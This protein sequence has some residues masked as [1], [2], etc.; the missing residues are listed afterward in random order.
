M[1][2]EYLES[3]YSSQ[4]W[5]TPYAIMNQQHER[6][7]PSCVFGE[8]Q[9]LPAHKHTP[10]VCV[11][12]RAGYA[13]HRRKNGLSFELWSNWCWWEV[14][15]LIEIHV[16]FFGIYSQQRICWV[17][18]SG[19]GDWRHENAARPE[20]LEQSENLAGTIR[21]WVAKLGHWG[22]HGDIA[23]NALMLSP[24]RKQDDMLSH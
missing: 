24:E 23:N 19:T 15:W 12:R 20:K 16:A 6:G 13:T 14:S 17:S 21:C 3:M 1:F 5:L 9:S 18:I 8:L 22:Y 10:Q 7:A 4:G 11:Q 2:E